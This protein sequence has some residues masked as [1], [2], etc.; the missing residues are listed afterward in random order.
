MKPIITVVLASSTALLLLPACG[1]DAKSTV[2]TT[3][4]AD[5][6]VTLPGGVTFPDSITIPEGVSIPSDLSIP[7]EAIDVMVAQMEAAGIKVDREC[8]DELLKDEDLRVLVNAS[9]TPSPEVIQ[10]F[11]ACF[12]P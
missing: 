8:L 2:P 11:V 10:K 3:A 5:A 6:A 1:S 7:Q 4:N 9:G 12:V